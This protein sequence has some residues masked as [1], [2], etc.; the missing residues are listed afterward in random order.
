MLTTAIVLLLVL[1]AYYSWFLL[2]ARAGL[3][4]LEPGDERIL[5]TALVSVVIAARN[6]EHTIGTCIQSVVRQS[7]PHENFEV[8]VVD[9]HSSDR[10]AE[11]VSNIAAAYDNVHLVA[12]SSGTTSE[13][14]KPEAIARGVGAA[15]GEII[16][17]TDA[18][19][20]V[21]PEWIAS[22][23]RY[24]RPDVA[25]VAGPVRISPETNLLS[26]LD[27][28]EVFGLL[29]MAA[30]LIGAHHPIIAN[31]ANLAYRK[32]AFQSVGGYGD[33]RTW[34]DDETI[35][36]RIHARQLGRIVFA[37]GVGTEAITA[38]SSTL[39]SFLRQRL[40]WS[41]SG[42]RYDDTSIL[43]SLVVLYAYFLVFSVLVLATAF[44]PA[45]ASW[46][47]LSFIIK[48]ITDVVTLGAGRKVLH[49]TVAWSIVAFAEILHVPYVLVTAAL[50][51]FVSFSWKGRT[52]NA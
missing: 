18:D 14:G 26:R 7:Y 1:T 46:L 34:C 25:F 47:V 39:G 50:G 15:R 32:S 51:Q 30:G 12:L 24:F 41:T 43:L 9:D 49:G 6:E 8:I 4:N 20:T 29:T 22:I 16:L 45:L 37:H 42:G 52:L 36:H 28:L 23:V 10:T 21:S 13:G 27:S 35:M 31:G 5:P 3:R 2:R 19:C 33:G 38:P 48:V 11:I 40:R 17:T 44:V